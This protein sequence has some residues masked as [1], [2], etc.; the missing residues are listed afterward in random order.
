MQVSVITLVALIACG[1]TAPAPAP[2]PE[3]AAKVEEPAP[4]PV[5][6]EE[7]AA[8]EPNVVTVEGDVAMVALEGTDQMKYNTKLIE[9]PAGKKVK[10]TLKHTGKLPAAAMGHNFVLLVPGTD[11]AAFATA[12]VKAKDTE[13]IPAAMAGQV[14]ANTGIVGGAD[15]D[16]KEVTIEFDAPDAGEYTFLC[17]FP[18]HYAMMNG[19]FKVVAEG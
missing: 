11:G 8:E 9:V 7:P 17:S 2:A 6:A 4:E 15:G 10:L 14:I 19:V 1:D 5:A 18:G 12:A 16:T 3:P 13:Y